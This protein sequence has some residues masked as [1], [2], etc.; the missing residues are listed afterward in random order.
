[1]IILLL[2][3]IFISVC[4]AISGINY[5]ITLLTFKGGRNVEYEK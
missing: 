1:M 4:I 2:I 3:A 5:I